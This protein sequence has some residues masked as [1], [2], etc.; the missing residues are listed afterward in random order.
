MRRDPSLSLPEVVK[1]LTNCKANIRKQVERVFRYDVIEALWTAKI[2]KWI[3]VPLF[4]AMDMVPYLG[5]IQAQ[6]YESYG[7]PVEFLMP[8]DVDE[9]T[10]F[11]DG[12]A[13]TKDVSNK[14]VFAPVSAKDVRNFGNGAW[15]ASC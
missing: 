15:G 2:A 9:E 6:L 4:K 7:V 3:R 5:P 14:K 10:E 11:P 8:H 13:N 1:F 12:K